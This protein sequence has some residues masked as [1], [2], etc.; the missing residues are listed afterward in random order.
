MTKQAKN[1]VKFATILWFGVTAAL[2]GF[3]TIY[4]TLKLAGNL[5]NPQPAI[6][7][8]P[9]AITDQQPAIATTPKAAPTPLNTA[10][11]EKSDTKTQLVKNLPNQITE[12]PKSK[13]LPVNV[14]GKDSVKSALT[15]L[16]KGEMAAFL[17][18]K[19]PIKLPEFTFMTLQGDLKDLSHWKGK[20]VLLNIWATW[21]VPCREEMPDLDKL[22]ATLGDKPFDVVT[23]NIDRGGMQKPSKFFKKHGIK[24]LTLFGSS[25]P[26]LTTL[27][28]A[29]GLPATLLISK[30]G[31]EIGRLIGPAKWASKDAIS[32]IKA[33]I[34]PAK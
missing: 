11:P 9:M 4:I 27:L 6:K 32:L 13:H 1:H 22:K 24:N 8:A 18:R 14:A 34:E 7:P 20:V 33:A 2:L 26:R 25:T 21:C 5:L 31:Q 16:N 10:P 12:I 19:T 17:I 15:G 23:I 30:K 28:R 29:P 3:A